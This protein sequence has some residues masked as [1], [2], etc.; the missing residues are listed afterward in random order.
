MEHV[1]KGVGGHHKHAFGY[2]T[3]KLK[4]I[5]MLKTWEHLM[6]IQE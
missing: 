4:S 3:S 1:Q 6:K 5:Q 2:N